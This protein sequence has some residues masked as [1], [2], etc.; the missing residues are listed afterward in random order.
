MSLITPDFGLLVWMVLIFGIVFFILAKFGFPMITGMVDKRAE[1]INESIAKAKEAEEKLLKLADE[2]ERMIAESRKEQS[3]ILT[4][5]SE[6]R[7][8][9]LARA[10]QE[11]SDEAEKI[12]KHAQIEIEARRE[13]AMSEIRKQVAEISIGVAEKILRRELSSD[14]RHK[15]FVDSLLDEASKTGMKE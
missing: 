11:A 5:A 15:E 3:R 13:A 12:L 1:R 9:I 7:E 10:K 4:E 8:E 6:A 2:H 14:S